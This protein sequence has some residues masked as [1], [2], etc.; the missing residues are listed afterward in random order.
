M[1][2]CTLG[3]ELYRVV[4][5][6]LTCGATADGDREVRTVLYS[7]YV[8]AACTLH[9]VTCLQ[10][11][12]AI[13]SHVVSHFERVLTFQCTYILVVKVRSVY[14]KECILYVEKDNP[15]GHEQLHVHVDNCGG[16]KSSCFIETM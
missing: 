3:D 12:F 1:V 8:A 6:L 5:L 13:M 14:V 9:V 4:E 11:L 10:Y 15:G 2:A 16:G 7:L